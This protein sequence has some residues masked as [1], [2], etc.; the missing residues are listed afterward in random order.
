VINA[1]KFISLFIT[2]VL[3]AA[4]AGAS[5][6]KSLG[7]AFPG[8]KSEL[9]SPDGKLRIVNRDPDENRPLH[10]IVLVGQNGVAEK[11]LHEYG[12]HVAV[13]WSP[14]SQHLTITDYAE[15]TDASC[16]LY[17][18][19]SDSK[20]DLGKEARQSDAQI[21]SLLKN[22]HAYFE[23]ARWLTSS[24]ISI[25]VKAWGRNNPNGADSFFEYTIGK[26]F[27]PAVAK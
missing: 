24:K 11:T 18:M 15:S 19:G 27:N 9:L 4:S 13:F 16:F 1:R 26:G 22:E 17:Q 2:S 7:A 14:D 20:I 8:P 3:L 21:A 6:G 23:C 25:K 10:T 12:R 5:E